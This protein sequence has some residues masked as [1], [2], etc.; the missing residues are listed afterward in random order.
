MV[1]LGTPASYPVCCLLHGCLLPLGCS[2]LRPQLWSSGPE[3][4]GVGRAPRPHPRLAPV[5]LTTRPLAACRCGLGA[6]FP[7]GAERLH[8]EGLFRGMELVRSS[9]P[10]PSGPGVCAVIRQLLGVQEKSLSWAFLGPALK[11]VRRA[12][13][14]GGESRLPTAQKPGAG[15][16]LEQAPQPW[17]SPCPSTEIAEES[18]KR[19]EG[20]D[21]LKANQEAEEDTDNRN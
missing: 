1:S 3:R 15:G 4:P 5:H 12:G 11:H 7:P 9:G 16:G 2:S 13:K 17:L 8:T 10:S 18:R 20:W 21:P 6:D 14:V 19:D